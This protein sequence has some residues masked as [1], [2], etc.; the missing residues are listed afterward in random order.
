MICRTGEFLKWLFADRASAQTL[1]EATSDR[2]LAKHPDEQRVEAPRC[3]LV[4]RLADERAAETLP[5][6]RGQDVDRVDLAPVR[7]VAGS[8]AATYRERNDL[9]GVL[10]DEAELIGRLSTQPLATP[11]G[12]LAETVDEPVRQ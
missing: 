6:V 11:V 9:A 7:R 4:R 1:V 3:E 10:G 5:L 2:V 8:L 12:I